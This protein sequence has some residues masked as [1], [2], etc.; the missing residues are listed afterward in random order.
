[1]MAMM[2]IAAEWQGNVHLP[3]PFTY[4]HRIVSGGTWEKG[5]HMEPH[6]SMAFCLSADSA[7]PVIVI[8]SVA[9]WKKRR[10][11]TEA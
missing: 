7:Q 4:R 2:A 9:A 5:G 11:T 6:V 10:G 3:L 8:N 1:M